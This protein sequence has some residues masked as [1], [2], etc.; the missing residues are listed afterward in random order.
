M[1][2]PNMRAE[3]LSYLEDLADVDGRQE[4]W[5][6]DGEE[7]DGAVHFIYDDTPLGDHP[8]RAVGF[9][10]KNEEE[11]AAV[12]RL[13][14]ALEVLFEKHGTQRGNAQVGAHAEW[15][16]V[17]ERARELLELLRAPAA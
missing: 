13:V 7:F 6:A 14:A 17:K 5:A 15:T 8:D 16:A 4:R 9:F 11:V 1:K 3:L 2:Y 10:L 12:K